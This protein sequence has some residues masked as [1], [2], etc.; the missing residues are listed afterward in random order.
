M[1][2][3]C[4]ECHRHAKNLEEDAILSKMTTRMNADALIVWWKCLVTSNSTKKKT[5]WTLSVCL[6]LS[7][8]SLFWM[9]QTCKKPWGICNSVQDDNKDECWCLNCVVKVIGHFW[10]QKKEDIL[11]IFYS[12]STVNG[13]FIVK[14]ATEMEITL[15]NMHFCPRWQRGWM[16]VH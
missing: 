3:H 6:L 4:K 15:R 7:D 10:F 12:M 11:D 1:T 8:I 9:P 5:Y 13:H 16:L 2:F 14:N